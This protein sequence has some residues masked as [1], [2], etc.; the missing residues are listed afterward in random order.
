MWASGEDSTAVDSD[1]RG[2]GIGGGDG[3]D[4]GWYGK[5]YEISQLFL[6]NTRQ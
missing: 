6:W 4:W 5:G 3:S 1:G 2:G